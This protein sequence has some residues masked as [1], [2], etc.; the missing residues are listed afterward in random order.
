MTI[1]HNHLRKELLFLFLSIMALFF[2]AACQ[3][4]PS[5]N[6][7]GTYVPDNGQTNI[8]VVDSSTIN[9]STVYTDSTATS[10]TGYL[11]VG[12]YTDPFLG[13]MSSTGYIQL[14][15]PVTLPTLNYL[16]DTYDSIGMVMIF[17]T[18]NPFYG[19][20]TVPQT[21][22][23]QEIDTLYQ[24][25]A[26]E[27][28]WYSNAG[29]PLGPS[30]GQGSVLI[31]PTRPTTT[32]NIDT[33]RIPMDYN[34]GQTLYNMVY[35]KSDTMITVK[36]FQQ[37]FP[38]LAISE[39]PGSQGNIYGF[40]DSSVMRIYYQENSAGGVSTT[41]YID[42]TLNNKSFQFNSL[43]ANWAGSAIANLAKPTSYS[44]PPPLTSSTQTGHA[45][46]VQTIGGLN[47][48]LTFPYLNAI[49]QRPDY[50]GLLRAELTVIPLAGSFSTT[51]T[52]PPQVGVYNTDLHNLIGAP[53][54]AVGSATPQ[55]G[56]LALNYFLPLQTS[57]TYDITNF[58][59]TQIVNTAPGA[60]S[61]GIMLSIPA[62][63]GDATF[64]R[65]VIADQS[66]PA[67][68]RIILSVYYISLYPHQ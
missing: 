34:L 44:Q 47:V 14:A 16:V 5:L 32:E 37:Y 28:G 35:N 45:S 3:K 41:K 10:A 39:A 23:V 58:V 56:N 40:R 38:G 52:L 60:D 55:T 12:S 25:P 43:R 54:L 8:I 61:T 66:Y 26:F 20:T 68:Q 53:V 21:Y 17:K 65:L 48:K 4:Q 51:Y 2:L 62:P 63:T 31:T 22:Q 6:F 11:M 29:P 13:Q 59:A 42:F 57:Y 15:P 19:D 9:M 30:I 1:I 7:G 33:V 46:Y 36:T 24:L 67:N 18:N 27:A 49:A 64:K 50:I